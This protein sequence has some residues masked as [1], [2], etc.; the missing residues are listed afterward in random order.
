MSLTPPLNFKNWI[1][2]NRHLLKPPV[3]NKVVYSGTDFLIMVVGGPNSRKTRVERWLAVSTH[4]RSR[5]QAPRPARGGMRPA[6]S[7]HRPRARD[8][9]APPPS[10]PL[11]KARA[12]GARA[13]QIQNRKH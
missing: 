5:D 11:P 1:D 9:G 2:E 7:P 8:R 4:T 12:R 10:R 13:K 3:G 6:E